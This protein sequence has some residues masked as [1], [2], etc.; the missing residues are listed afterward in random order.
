MYARTPG[1]ERAESPAGAGGDAARP[2]DAADYDK[3]LSDQAGALRV[4]SAEYARTRESRYLRAIERVDA[5]LLE[6][7]ADGEGLFF[8][9]QWFPVVDSATASS[10]QI[11]TADYWRLASEHERRQFGLPRRSS[12]RPLAANAALACAYLLAARV[13]ADPNQLALA[14][15]IGLGLQAL[16]E[17]PGG[18]ADGGLA[19]EAELLALLSSRARTRVSLPEQ[20]DVREPLPEAVVAYGLMRRSAR[21]EGSGCGLGGEPEGELQAGDQR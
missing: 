8:A 5:Y 10:R 12:D 15:R 11:G 18:T 16:G 13:T 9:G 17:L 3:R 6:W 1:P 14:R 4:F 7:L 2:S 19:S 20:V 21:P